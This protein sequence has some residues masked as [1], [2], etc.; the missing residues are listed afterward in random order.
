MPELALRDSGSADEVG[1]EIEA[2]ED[3]VIA[4]N[5][6]DQG[7]GCR[8]RRPSRR[9]RDLPRRIHCHRDVAIG[10]E[11]RRFTRI[12]EGSEYHKPSLGFSFGL[13]GF[14]RGVSRSQCSLSVIFFEFCYISV[15]RFLCLLSVEFWTID[16]L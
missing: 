11:E 12:L 6:G 7:R 3:V 15:N 13:S 10:V 2:E 4:Q 5:R 16:L 1:G 8:L 14:W 9:L